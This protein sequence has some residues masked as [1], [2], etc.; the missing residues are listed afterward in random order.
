MENTHVVYISYDGMTDPLGQSQVIPYLIGLSKLGITYSLV[1]F[2][3]H[4][5]YE[6]NKK[7]ISALLTN[8]NIE[9][10]PLTY[11]AKPPVLS[12]LYD[13]YCLFKQIKLIHKNK[14]IKILHCRSYISALAGLHFK[15][16]WGVKFIF[17]MRGFW[18]D[19]R[20]D[21]KIWNLSNPI[22]KTIY[23]YFK[24]KEKQYI[25]NADAIISLT[26]NAKE[27]IHSWKYIKNNPVYIQV[28]PCCADFNHFTPSSIDT[29][30]LFD[31]KKS[32]N[33]ADTDF[34]LSYVG[35][36]GTW[37]MLP[38]MFEFFK[39]LLLK[40]NK[41]KFLIIT[42]DSQ[43]QIIAEA[44]KNEVPIEKLIIKK[45]SRVDMPYYLMLSTFSVF[46]IKPAYSKKA[47]SPTKLAEIL[48]MG[49][50]VICNKG[51]G[52]VDKIVTD[53]DVGII[54]NSFATESYNTAID[55]IE[56]YLA[57]PK[58]P[59]VDFA[60]Q[61]ASLENGVEKYAEVYKKVLAKN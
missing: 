32:L 31:L 48:G 7:I 6:E 33:I 16:K 49:V 2:E 11:H 60:K 44:H 56:N 22:F 3:K 38:Q 17:D 45:S 20:V 9:W 41:A 26:H 52:D 47:S 25:E 55:K 23:D 40:Y 5:R 30:K 15:K 29:Q 14:P 18:A 21:G 51:V 53:G 46:F 37:Y 42:A 13:I 27:E 54:L 35:S 10:F 57:K 34:V 12:T 50:Q 36:V 4:E 24:N 1:S 58:E 39:A 19:E 43:E 59:I 61:Y 8:N 28:I